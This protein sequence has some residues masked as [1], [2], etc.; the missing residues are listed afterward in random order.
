MEAS[1]LAEPGGEPNAC[2]DA[3]SRSDR[4]AEHTLGLGSARVAPPDHTRR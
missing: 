3:S 1:S 2:S 4:Y